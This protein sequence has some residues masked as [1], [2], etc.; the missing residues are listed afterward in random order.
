M[1]LI[2]IMPIRGINI[3]RLKFYSEIRFDY[4]LDLHTKHYYFKIINFRNTDGTNV[5]KLKMLVLK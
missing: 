2:F 4:S 1:H 5:A 3:S